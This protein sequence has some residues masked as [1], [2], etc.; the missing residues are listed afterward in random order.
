MGMETV[1]NFSMTMKAVGPWT[2]FPPHTFRIVAMVCPEDEGGFSVIGL[3]L[4]GCCTQGE[5]MPEC[6]ENLKEAATA[7][8]ETYRLNESRIPW[9]NKFETADFPAG[10]VRVTVYVTVQ[11]KEDILRRDEQQGF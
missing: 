3:N 11:T 6:L 1:G 9:K 10:S 4:P 2:M 5:T 7:L 8:I